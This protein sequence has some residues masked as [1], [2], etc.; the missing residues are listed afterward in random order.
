MQDHEK[1]NTLTNQAISKLLDFGSVPVQKESSLRQMLEPPIAELLNC[2]GTSKKESSTDTYVQPTWAQGKDRVSGRNAPTI[3][4]KAFVVAAWIILVLI[5]GAVVGNLG[6]KLE[7]PPSLETVQRNS[8]YLFHI[9]MLALAGC[10]L[11]LTTWLYWKSKLSKVANIVVVAVIILSGIL[12]LMTIGGKSKTTGMKRISRA[13][14][15]SSSNTATSMGERVTGV[16]H[17]NDRPAAIIGYRIV[18]EGE[19]I[20]DV[21]VVKIHKDKVEFE[22]GD[23]RWTQ[24]IQGA[25]TPYWE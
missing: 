15:S 8:G 13:L 25:P 18:H 21:K 16:L 2:S 3:G 4:G 17:S 7:F 20:R 23:R 11:S 24:T 9:S 10:V 22:K 14:F 1:D 19:V 5:V 12:P 6:F